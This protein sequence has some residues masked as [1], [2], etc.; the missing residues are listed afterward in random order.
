MYSRGCGCYG[1]GGKEAAHHGEV[2]QPVGLLG[3]CHQRQRRGGMADGGGTFV[4]SGTGVKGVTVDRAHGFFEDEDT[5]GGRALPKPR[6]QGVRVHVH[7]QKTQRCRGGGGGGRCVVLSPVPLRTGGSGFDSGGGGGFDG[8][9][10]F[11]GAWQGD[12]KRAQVQ[13]ASDSA[14]RAHTPQHRAL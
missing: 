2:R 13:H 9:F 1:Y 4:D 7:V 12:G 10:E 14:V 6:G 3:T 5:G 8:E 11:Y